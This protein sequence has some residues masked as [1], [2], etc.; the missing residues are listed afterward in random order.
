MLVS[1]I[2]VIIL[3]GA[4]CRAEPTPIQDTLTDEESEVQEDGIDLPEITEVQ[5]DQTDYE[6]IR[7]YS[8]KSIEE[9][10]S[11]YKVYLPTIRR[12]NTEK[13]SRISFPP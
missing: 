12:G 10:L 13:K 8:D 1:L 11:A 3:F 4:G 5:L 2:F 7:S 6:T 9:R